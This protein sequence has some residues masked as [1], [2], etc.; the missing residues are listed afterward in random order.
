[1]GRIIHSP[2]GVLGIILFIAGAA[3]AQS[4]IPIE[5]FVPSGAMHMPSLSPSGAKAVYI[6]NAEGK[7]VVVV[8]DV[9]TGASRGVVSGVSDSYVVRQRRFKNDERLLCS[10]HGTNHMGG[11]PYG[12]SRLVSLNADGTDIEVLFNRSDAF[13]A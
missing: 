8:T 7:L 11:R 3:H 13:D 5:H 4:L 2:A 10:Y 6:A 1:M 12:T 9:E